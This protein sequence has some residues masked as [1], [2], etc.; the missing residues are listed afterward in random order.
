MG[1]TDETDTAIV[2]VELTEAQ[3]AKAARYLNALPFVTWA[4]YVAVRDEDGDIRVCVYG[5]IAREDGRSDFVCLYFD[6]DP[7]GLFDVAF[8][9]SSAK[10]SETINNVVTGGATEHFPCRRVEEGFGPLIERTT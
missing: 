9:T 8:A 5:W 10:H 7:V 2:P 3:R 4:R 6:F 1:M